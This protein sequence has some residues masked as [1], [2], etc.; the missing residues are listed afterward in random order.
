MAVGRSEK[1]P[2]A[3][4]VVGHVVTSG[5]SVALITGGGAHAKGCRRSMPCALEEVGGL[6]SGTLEHVIGFLG[7]GP[8][9]ESRGPGST[10]GSSE[11]LRSHPLFLGLV[12]GRHPLFV[13]LWW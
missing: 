6:H 2:W 4:A 7:P 8:C 12:R 11:G 1:G 3:V 10:R 5:L 9:H 13:G